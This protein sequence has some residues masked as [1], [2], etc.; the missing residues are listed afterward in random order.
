MKVREKN[1]QDYLDTVIKTPRIK[2]FLNEKAPHK[3]S[4]DFRPI[5]SVVDQ[6]SKKNPGQYSGMALGSRTIQI[7]CWICVDKDQSFATVRHELAHCIQSWCELP[8]SYH[9]RGFTTAL[10]LVSQR[11]WRNDRY[12][13]STSAV[14]QARQEINNMFRSVHD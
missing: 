12:W 11:T 8:G 6:V 14:E 4:S 2:E 3:V 7:S 10:K 9:G 5:L 1:L 13:K